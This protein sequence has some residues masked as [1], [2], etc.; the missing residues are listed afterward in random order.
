MYILYHSESTKSVLSIKLTFFFKIMYLNQV[1]SFCIE[2]LQSTFTTLYILVTNQKQAKNP[3]VPTNKHKTAS[4]FIPGFI[5]IKQFTKNIIL[6]ISVS[7]LMLSLLQYMVITFSGIYIQSHNII[8]AQCQSSLLAI[9]G[10]S[11]VCISFERKFCGARLLWCRP[12]L[13]KV[14]PLPTSGGR[15]GKDSTGIFALEKNKHLARNL[16]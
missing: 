9:Q 4:I 8:S 3:I 15:L 12:S 10:L 16:H 14:K 1:D 11:S 7:I 5:L 6:H 13:I 2:Y